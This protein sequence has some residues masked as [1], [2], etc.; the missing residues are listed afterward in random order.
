MSDMWEYLT[1]WVCPWKRLVLVDLPLGSLDLAY[2]G[3]VFHWPIVVTLMDIMGFPIAEINQGV[4]TI[5][6]ILLMVLT[7]LRVINERKRGKQLD[8][9]NG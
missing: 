6:G 3:V 5:T 9:D 8:K 1:N 4:A 7:G 2:I